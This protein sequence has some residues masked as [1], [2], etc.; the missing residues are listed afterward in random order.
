M[1]GLGRGKFWRYSRQKV[2]NPS[3][4]HHDVQARENGGPEEYWGKGIGRKSSETGDVLEAELSAHSNGLNM[5]EKRKVNDRFKIPGSVYGVHGTTTHWVGK[6]RH[7]RFGFGEGWWWLQFGC[8]TRPCYAH[9]PRFSH[10]HLP[11]GF[12]HHFNGDPQL[13]SPVPTHLISHQVGLG[14]VLFSYLNCF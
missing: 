13:Q 3:G 2:R 4:A 6:H 8:Y 12:S 9:C 7:S 14:T 1:L 5:G 11:P 10:P